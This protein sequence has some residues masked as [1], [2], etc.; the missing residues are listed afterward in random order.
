MPPSAEPHL[1]VALEASAP[2][3]NVTFAVNYELSMVDQ[4]L[5]SSHR[6]KR[7]VTGAVTGKED[8]VLDSTSVSTTQAMPTN[9]STGPDNNSNSNNNN[10]NIPTTARRASN[11]ENNAPNFPGKEKHNNILTTESELKKQVAVQSPLPPAANPDTTRRSAREKQK[12]EVPL[13]RARV[14]YD[15]QMVPPAGRHQEYLKSFPSWWAVRPEGEQEQ[16]RRSSRLTVIPGTE[17][18]SYPSC[19]QCDDSRLDPFVEDTSVVWIPSKRLEW[20]DTVSEMTAVCT[21]AALR[22]Y[23]KEQQQDATANTKPFHAP[24][25]RDY[26]RDRVDID[27][28]LNGYQIRHKTGGW[29][30]G[31]ILWTNFTAWTYY[32][33][34]DSLDAA[35]RVPS[36]ASTPTTACSKM[37]VDGSL[38]AELEAQPRSGDPLEGGIVFE[39]IAEVALV[40]GLGCGE[41]ALRMALDDIR[42]RQTY[43]YVVLQATEASKSFYE[44]FGFVRVGAVCRYL[45][46]EK[47]APVQ[48]YRHWTHANESESSLHLHGGPSYMMCLKLPEPDSLDEGCF[49]CG[50]PVDEMKP[51]FLKDM[52]TL[53]VEQKPTIELLGATSTPGPKIGKR[54]GAVTAPSG[55]L[56]FASGGKRKYGRRVSG[57]GSKRKPNNKSSV[58]ASATTSTPATPCVAVPT[59]AAAKRQLQSTNIKVA[60]VETK[61]RKLDTRTETLPERHHLAPPI[62]GQALSYNQKQYQSVWLAVPP[63]SGAKGSRSAPKARSMDGKPMTTDPCAKKKS[64]KKKAPARKMASFAIDGSLMPSAELLPGDRSY[65]SKRGG[66]GRFSR[67]LDATSPMN[68]DAITDVVETMKPPAPIIATTAM[69]PTATS[70]TATTPTCDTALVSSPPRGIPAPLEN[71]GK[72]IPIDKTILIKQKVKSYPRSRVHFYNRVVKRK[73]G[74]IAECFFVLNYDEA[75]GRARIVP[76]VA[77]GKLSGKREGRPRFQ[78]VIESS[79]SNFTTVAVSEI[80]L[81]RSAMVMKTPIVASEAWDIEE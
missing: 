63:T 81:V 60:E 29:L 50:R 77:R 51:S 49:S 43:K 69:P 74:T 39:G 3:T 2:T 25:S 56:L 18:E 7:G 64:A 76:M 44:R 22:R 13:A 78:A 45:A 66:N 70:A 40:G 75:K 36:E 21:S 72:P 65:Y 71:S 23:L 41:Y 33:R 80:E 32:F 27:D 19:T 46:G 37:D 61:R 79:D 52:L 67:P 58:P 48:G 62:D 10:N 20:E 15:M 55:E 14:R 4:F 59:K 17:D 53:A 42:N 1:D 8:P 73:G 12:R 38:T 6:K 35:S 24:L 26:I 68:N 11:M 57:F 30:Q 28:P 5:A 54:N 9:C 31:F 16:P 47:E 34:W